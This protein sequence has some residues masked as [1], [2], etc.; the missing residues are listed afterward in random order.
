MSAH[1]C[2]RVRYSRPLGLLFLC[3][4]LVL[5]LSPSVA[6][7]DD[8]TAGDRQLSLQI[9]ASK[10]EFAVGDEAVVSLMA[11]NTGGVLVE[12]ATLHL[13]DQPGV[14]WSEDFRDTWLELGDLPPGESRVI[15]GRVRV[16][17]LPANGL[18]P[19]FATL[20]GYDTT[21]AEASAQLS[22]P[23][24]PPKEVAVSREGS[25]VDTAG[26]LVRFAFPADWHESD[27]RLTFRL[28]EQLPQAA[29]ETGRLLLFAV[30][31]TAGDSAIDS[32]DAAATVTVDLNGLVDPAWAAERPPVV[33]TRETKKENWTAVESAFDPKTSLL[34]FTTTH[35][36]AYQVT[37]EPQIWKLVYNPPGA[38]AYTG[39]A[40]YHY[41]IQ[42]PPG[43]GGLTPELSLNYS[44]RP[45][46]SMRAPVMSFGFGAGWSFPQAQIN[47]GNSG[48]MYS[49]TDGS[50]NY[51]PYKFTLLLNGITYYLQPVN[52]SV[53]YGAFRA[54]GGPEL[55]IE[56]I[57]DGSGR[58][59][60]NNVSGEFWRVTTPDGTDYTFGRTMDS[61][62]VIYPVATGH[63]S[64]QPRNN[65]FSPYNWKLDLIQDV[66]G[67]K[68]EYSYKSACGIGDDGK[69]RQASLGSGHNYAKQC[70]EVD[71][72]LWEV[73][74]NFSGGSPQTSVLF[75]YEENMNGK[76]VEVITSMTAG[77]YRPTRIDVKQN[78][79]VLRSYSFAYHPL[80]YH[81]HAPWVGASQF[82]MLKSI[83]QTGA[84]GVGTLPAQTFTYN[85]IPYKGCAAGDNQGETNYCV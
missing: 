84:G 21:P 31:A 76:A 6:S 46:D 20:H 65:A 70:T 39:A 63:N 36:S 27:A 83:S 2:A 29:G 5:I 52:T 11:T 81:F 37:T 49:P 68:V 18:L 14:E 10:G 19:L 53:R 77:V 55:L 25:L 61:E 16:T 44:S 59:D 85:L 9:D 24:P 33:S 28:Q 43:I 40:T 35:F 62:Q 56:F 41:P 7:Q 1:A 60:T 42:L 47:N 74:Y 45:V 22:L 17:G 73:K 15:E 78:N 57:E 69:P 3:L 75:T 72:A 50:A 66:H 13:H 51:A 26:G 30:E 82:W 34:T 32:F 8:D 67:N 80:G 48:D 58:N 38:S 54:I 79:A 4:V 64:G 23:P 12:A 71:T